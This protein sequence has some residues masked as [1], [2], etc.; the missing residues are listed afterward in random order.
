MDGNRRWAKKN[1]LALMQGHK[2]MVREN[3]EML[4]DHSIKRGIKYLTMWV[5]STENWNRSKTEVAGLMNLFREAFTKNAARIHERDVKIVTI[6]DISRFAE[7]IRENIKY[8]VE[9]TKN[10]KKL[11]LVFALNYGGRDEILR[12][13]SKLAVSFVNDD[14]KLAQLKKNIQH[15]DQS[16]KIFPEQLFAAFLDTHGLPDPDL[17]IRLGGEKRMS[18]FMPW[19]AVYSEFYFTDALAPEFNAQQFDEALAEFSRRQRRFGK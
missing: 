16:T 1:G 3:T 4:I 6:G 9:K 10:N 2:K 17:I 7:D 19:Q 14:K 18:G 8:W 11:T 12:A 15:I 5:F 13:V